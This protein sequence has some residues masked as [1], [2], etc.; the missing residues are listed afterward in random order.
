MPLNP[1][2]RELR[3][4]IYVEPFS[5]INFSDHPNT[6]APTDIKR[7]S[8]MI[9]KV[10]NPLVR[11]WEAYLRPFWLHRH[12]SSTVRELIK[13]EDDN[14]SYN[15]LAPVNKALQMT[16]VY[17]A[18]GQGSTSLAR[19][20][21]TLPSY[22]WQSDEGMT[23]SGT[24]GVQVWDTAFTVLAAVEAG[25]AKDQRFKATMSRALDFLDVSQLRENLTDPYRQR[26][27]GGWAFSTRE[28]GYIVSDC[29][30][31]SMKAVIMLQE[32]W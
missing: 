31:E 3:G 14:T 29:S 11:T 23:S 17:F 4:E 1:L 22:L 18:D 13:R 21:E 15:D 24:N 12:A 28:N 27:K 5:S 10:M 19:H 7:P 32:E 16:A 2:L 26:R 25:L 6:I 30:A 9:M 8:G 20:R